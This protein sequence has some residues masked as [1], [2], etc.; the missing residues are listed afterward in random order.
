MEEGLLSFL[1]DANDSVL[2][3]Q[4]EGLGGLIEPLPAPPTATFSN[5]ACHPYNPERENCLD[6]DTH[7]DDDGEIIKICQKNAENLL[8]M[9]FC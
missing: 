6:E 7:K 2:S 4:V 5:P 3:T 1:L 9:R 8:S